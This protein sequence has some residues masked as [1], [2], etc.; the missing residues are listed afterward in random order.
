M[1]KVKIVD[2]SHLNEKDESRMS[3]YTDLE[4]LND[5]KDVDKILYSV[6]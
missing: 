4:I 3:L 2:G 1:K 5:Y 6:S